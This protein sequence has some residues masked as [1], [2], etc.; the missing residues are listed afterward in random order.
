MTV[1]KYPSAS[2]RTRGAASRLKRSRLQGLKERTARRARERT[3]ARELAGSVISLAALVGTDV[4]DADGKS[5]GR[6][7]DVVVHWTKASV[8]PAV[9][10]I[11]VRVGGR[12]LMIGAR[13]VELSAPATV[14][15][16]SSAAY[17]RAAERRPADVALAHDVL[18]RQVI[19][20]SGL[21]LMR[22]AD[23]YLANVAG[24]LELVGIEVGP[25]ALL[26]RLGPRRLR[27][28]VRPERVISWAEIRSFSM[29]RDEVARARGRRSDLAGKA[30]AG[31]ELDLPTGDLREL[32]ASEAQ[33]ALEALQDQQ[34][35]RESP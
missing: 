15:L 10:A 7:R 35:G 16:R 31:L 32:G 29:A 24:R 27:G 17:A 14:R 12:N 34:Q 8:H 20:A 23:V 30:G 25:R 6:L 11:V 28:R 33:A 9:T 4:R 5:V 13:W 21:E 19:D 1:S 22:P 2:W 26:R 3:A 18:D